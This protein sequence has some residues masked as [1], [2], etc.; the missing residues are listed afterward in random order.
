MTSWVS[1]DRKFD[2]RVPGKR[3]M[4]AFPPG[5]HFMTDEQ[6]DEAERVGAGRRV[7]KPE[8]KRTTKAGQT[9]DAN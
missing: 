1:L 3:A 7:D 8:G 5:E 9:K 4:K 6:A 2:W